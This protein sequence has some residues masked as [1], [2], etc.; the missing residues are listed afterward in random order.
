MPVLFALPRLPVILCPPGQ[1]TL[2][3]Q[4]EFETHVPVEELCPRTELGRAVGH[5]GA[6]AL[7]PRP[8]SAERATIGGTSGR[9]RKCARWARGTTTP[10][11]SR[12][13]GGFSRSGGSFS[14]CR[15]RRY[16]SRRQHSG[17]WR[18]GVEVERDH[19]PRST[20]DVFTEPARAGES[21]TAGVWQRLKG[22]PA[23]G[24]RGPRVGSEC[25]V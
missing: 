20:E 17:L 5:R 16:T 9:W 3:L 24:R 8:G 22:R 11:K 13:G 2:S 18:L 1:H 23:K 15:S 25:G 12:A 10:R 7:V 6:S 4:A 21:A 19:L 14:S